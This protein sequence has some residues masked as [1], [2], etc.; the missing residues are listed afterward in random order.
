MQSSWSDEWGVLSGES[1]PFVIFVVNTAVAEN[2]HSLC[3]SKPHP[4]ESPRPEGLIRE[5]GANGWRSNPALMR[6][7][8]LEQR[9]RPEAPLVQQ[10]MVNELAGTVGGHSEERANE[11]A[12]FAEEV[13]VEVENAHLL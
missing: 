3:T 12:V 6:R 1:G 9:R 13:G 4:P 7:T 10:F 11:I 8:D 5:I 2:L